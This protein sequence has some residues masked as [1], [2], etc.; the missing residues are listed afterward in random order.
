[1]PRADGGVSLCHRDEFDSRSRAKARGV[2]P[3]IPAYLDGKIL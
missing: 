3:G 2:D 1:M